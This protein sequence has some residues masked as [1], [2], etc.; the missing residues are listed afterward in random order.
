MQPL[1]CHQRVVGRCR[2]RRRRRG[3]SLSAVIDAPEMVLRDEAALA[4]LVAD[5]GECEAETE[6]DKYVH[7]LHTI[8]SQIMYS[9]T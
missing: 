4:G 5:G 9:S 8:S 3:H 6:F 7:V 1:V 2:R